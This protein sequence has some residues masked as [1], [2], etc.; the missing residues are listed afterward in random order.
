M[1]SAEYPPMTPVRATTQPWVD[2]S[3]QDLAAQTAVAIFLRD[4]QE[5]LKAD[6][7]KVTAVTD[8]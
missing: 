1:N 3:Q 5:W 2:Y 6:W 8:K 4:N 7:V